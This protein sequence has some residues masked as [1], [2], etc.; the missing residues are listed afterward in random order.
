MC[1]IYSFMLNNVLLI[2][3]GAGL[4]SVGFLAAALAERIRVPRV[5]DSRETVLRER[6][7]VVQGPSVLP[8]VKTTRAPRAE[9]KASPS[10]EGGEVV[11][12][13]LVAAG[14]KKSFAAEA[15]WACSAAE[16]LTVESWIAGALRRCA[17]GG[18]P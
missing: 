5:Q 8:V 16:R 17:R 4:V 15:T 3:L 18:L 14:Y 1:R 12:T 2:L 13:A 11:I 9:T 7:P 6:S 10:S